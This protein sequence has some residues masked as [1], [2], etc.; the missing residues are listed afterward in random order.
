MESLTKKQILSRL[1][2]L[3]KTEHPSYSLSIADPLKGDWDK[4]DA[5]NLTT[6]N[7]YLK[8]QNIAVSKGDF[9]LLAVRVTKEFVE[10]FG[11]KPRRREP[12]KSRWRVQKQSL[13]LYR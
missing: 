11:V 2:D 12:S 13:C 6:L 7:E 8:Q 4:E 3:L 5:S 1:A 10:T 9:H